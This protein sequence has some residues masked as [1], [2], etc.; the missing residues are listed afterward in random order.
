MSFHDSSRL[1]HVFKETFDPSDKRGLTTG[2]PYVY[3]G[4]V[5]CSE[6]GVATQTSSEYGETVTVSVLRQS[7]QEQRVVMKGT[8]TPKTTRRSERRERTIGKSHIFVSGSLR[9]LVNGLGSSVL[10]RDRLPLRK[11]ITS[12][13]EVQT[14]DSSP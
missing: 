5:S 1:C 2:R 4:D 13:T 8:T 7:L 11:E 9:N 14:S 6:T 10:Q 3:Q 12:W